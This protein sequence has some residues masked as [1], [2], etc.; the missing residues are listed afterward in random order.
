MDPNDYVATVLTVYGIETIISIII[1][2][3][4]PTVATVL[5]VYGIETAKKE[6]ST[7]RPKVA[8]VLTVYGIETCIRSNDFTCKLS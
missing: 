1:F 5:T 4:I 8:T 7:V 6:S 3:K 2:F